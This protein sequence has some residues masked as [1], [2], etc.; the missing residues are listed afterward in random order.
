MKEN[1]NDRFKRLATIR[2]RAILQ[3][4][5]ILGN[6]SN[7]NAYDYTDAEIRTIFN[8]IEEQLREVRGRFRSTKDKEFHL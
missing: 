1:K 7:K 4:I 6:C 3:K 2:T 5:R 8:A